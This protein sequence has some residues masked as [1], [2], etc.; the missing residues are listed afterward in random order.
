M[1]SSAVGAS[2]DQNLRNMRSLIFSFN[3]KMHPPAEGFR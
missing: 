3:V 2:I 1:R